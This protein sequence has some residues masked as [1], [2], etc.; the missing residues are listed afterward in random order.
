[1]N[2]VDYLIAKLAEVVPRHKTELITV[3]ATQGTSDIC[4]TFTRSM[5]IL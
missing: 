4:S 2:M 5:V 1:M 3:K